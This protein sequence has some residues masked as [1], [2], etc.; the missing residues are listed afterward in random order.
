MS[1]LLY[2][3]ILPEGYTG[4]GEKNEGIHVQPNFLEVYMSI[5][6]FIRAY[7]KDFW[8]ITVDA[9]VWLARSMRGD[10]L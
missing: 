2:R 6:T 5:P 3:S 9:S 8:S 4:P 10:K 1:E 7:V